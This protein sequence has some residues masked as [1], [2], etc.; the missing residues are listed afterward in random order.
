MT[1]IEANKDFVIFVECNEKEVALVE[2]STETDAWATYPS[3]RRLIRDLSGEPYCL[4]YKFEVWLAKN[5]RRIENLDFDSNVYVTEIVYTYR[6]G[7]EI[8]DR[9]GWVGRIFDV[10]PVKYSPSDSA[11]LNIP[12]KDLG[13]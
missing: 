10:A 2:F 5:G 13:N 8:M 3:Y 11:L 4:D 1:E 7:Q 12:V 6:N 9:I